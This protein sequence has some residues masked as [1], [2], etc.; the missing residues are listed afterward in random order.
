MKKF[1]LVVMVFILGAYAASAYIFGGQARDQYFSALK[2]YERYGFVSLSN[3]SYERGFFTSRAQTLVEVRFPDVSE[4]AGG[5]VSRFVLSHALRH[6][7]LTGGEGKFSPGLA[8]ITSTVEPV[9]GDAVSQDFFVA[10]PEMAQ[11][12]SDIHVGFDGDV[13][14]DVRIP[15]IDRNIDGEHV[16]WGG[17]DLRAEYVP[18]SRKLSGSLTMPSLVV[19]AG[20]G[21]T[22]LEA[23]TGEFDLVEVLPLVY[24]GRVDAGVSA[25]GIIP[26]EGEDVRVKNLRLSSNSSCDES[27]YHFAQ[28][29]GVESV[30]VGAS[31]YG[32]ASCELV[33]K[34]INATALSEFQSSLQEL[35]RDM[36]DTDSE[37][38]YDRVGQ[39]YAG[40]FAKVLAG[41]PELGMPHLQ[42]TTPLGDLKGAFSVKLLSP[43]ADTALNPLLL[44][45]HLEAG[46]QMAVHEELLKGML[47]IGMEKE[48]GGENLEEMVQQRYAERIEPLVA[49]NLL[50]REAGILSGTASFSNGQLTVNGKEMPLF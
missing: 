49:Q 2:E 32:P 9:A 29:I 22:E 38:F 4:E 48:F 20:E 34:N 43:V 21:S 11:T 14:G 7:P 10:V 37:V 35:Y 46:A 19:K 44:L 18:S 28:N 5:N 36:G 33:G 24:A 40:L 47:R 45:Q 8:R 42:V 16:A 27:L 41:K 30:S 13:A 3:Q 1:A 12:V 26:A 23:M 6:G 15:A 17:L 25:M 31:T 50:V 39:L